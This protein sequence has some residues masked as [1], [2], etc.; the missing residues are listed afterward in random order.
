MVSD[1][2]LIMIKNPQVYKKWQTLDENER[3]VVSHL[4]FD[5][6]LLPGFRSRMKWHGEVIS[7]RGNRFDRFVIDI[8]VGEVAILVSSSG[9]MIPLDL[10]IDDRILKKYIIGPHWSH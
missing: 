10:Y 7:S 5:S 3:R 8:T 6:I 9:S 1:I 2:D 4:F